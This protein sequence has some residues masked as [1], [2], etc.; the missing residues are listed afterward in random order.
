MHARALTP[1]EYFVETEPCYEATG[2][3]VVI[4]AA[5][6]N[7]KLPVLP[8]GTTGCGKRR[9]IEYMAW[10]LKRPLITVSCHDDL[11][12]SNLVG[13]FLIKGGETVRPV[14]RITRACALRS[15]I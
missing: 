9:F 5:A 3:V 15:A 13:R 8:K 6:Y 12:A 14:Y 7:N 4:F 10:R 1:E 2:D 11:T